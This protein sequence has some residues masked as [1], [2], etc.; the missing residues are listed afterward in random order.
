MGKFPRSPRQAQDRPKT[1]IAS[2]HRFLYVWR[3]HSST[4]WTRTTMPSLR[5]NCPGPQ[6]DIPI[7]ARIIQILH[8][9]EETQGRGGRL[10]LCE[11]SPGVENRHRSQNSIPPQ[12]KTSRYEPAACH[13]GHTTPHQLE[14]AVAP[15]GQSLLHA[16]HGYRD[17]STHLTHTAHLVTGGGRIG[18]DYRQIFTEKLMTGR[19]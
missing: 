16:P 17:G 13:P 18:P 3:D 10:D 6:M 2:P 11:R 5:P 15:G 19:R 9:R 8:E 7:L 12:A 4:G 1:W 14:V